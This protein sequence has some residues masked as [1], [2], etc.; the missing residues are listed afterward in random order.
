MFDSQE[1]PPCFGDSHRWS[2]WQLAA[3]VSYPV[4]RHGMPAVLFS[5]VTQLHASLHGSFTT[6]AVPFAASQ[7]GYPPELPSLCFIL[8]ISDYNPMDQWPFQSTDSLVVLD[9]HEVL[10]SFKYDILE[11]DLLSKIPQAPPLPIAFQAAYPNPE[12]TWGGEGPE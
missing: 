4:F 10:K 1:Q 3:G 5:T 2:K 8:W 12:S 9:Q 7:S 6:Q 11:E